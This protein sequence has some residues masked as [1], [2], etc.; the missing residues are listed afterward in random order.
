MASS[1]TPAVLATYVKAGEAKAFTLVLQTLLLRLEG[2]HGSVLELVSQVVAATLGREARVTIAGSV[3]KGTEVGASDLDLLVETPAPVTLAQRRALEVRLQVRPELNAAHVQLKKLAIHVHFGGLDVDIVCTNTV[4]YGVQ[5][6]PDAR[7]ASADAAVKLAARALK[8]WARHA[9]SLGNRKVPGHALESLVLHCRPL[10]R[11]AVIGDS[12][13]QLFVDVLQRIA[14]AGGEL[15]AA[16]RLDAA[17]RASLRHR[18]LATLHVFAVSRVLLPGGSFRTAAEVYAWLS[19]VPGVRPPCDTPAGAVP[20]WLLQSPS[21]QR[22]TDMHFEH[23]EADT[24]AALEDTGLSEE[25]AKTHH[26]LLLMLSSPLGAFTTAAAPKSQSRKGSDVVTEMEALA[27]HAARGSAV[28]RRM[29]LAREL[30]MEAEAAMRDT[31]SNMARAVE[32]FSA[33]LRASV[34][35]GDPF[36]G[37]VFGGLAAYAACADAVLASCHSDEDALLLRAWALHRDGRWTDA[38][39]VHTAVIEQREPDDAYGA[40]YQRYN[41]RGNQGRWREALVDVERCAELCPEEP[42]FHYWIAVTRRNL[43]GPSNRSDGEIC[44]A[45]RRFL[46]LAS[47]EGRKVAPALYDMA[48]LDLMSAV[49]G[50]DR[51]ALLVR[52]RENVRKA[53]DAEALQL[54]VFPPVDCDAK[55][56]V[57]ELICVLEQPTVAKAVAALRQGPAAASPEQLRKEGNAAFASRKFSEA[58]GAYSQALQMSPGSAELLANRAAARTALRFFTAAAEDAAAAAAARPGWSKPHYRAAQAHLGRKDGAAALVAAQRASE[59]LPADESVTRVLSEAKQLAILQSTAAPLPDVRRRPQVW[60]RVAFKENAHIVSPSGGAAFAC[61]ADALHELLR[62]GAAGG[63]TLILLPGVHVEAALFITEP[64]QLLGWADPSGGADVSELRLLAD[65]HTQRFILL[66]AVG[67]KDIVPDINDEGTVCPVISGGEV[68]LEWLRLVQPVGLPHGGHC[69]YCTGGASLRVIGCSAF[70]PDAPCFCTNGAGSRLSLSGVTV[71]RSSAAVVVQGGE[72]QAEGCTFT[73]CAR[74]AVEA[75]EGGEAVLRGCSFNKCS[76]QAALIYQSGKRL[77]LHS[78]TVKQCGGF[79][80]S[81]VHLNEGI[82]LL[83]DCIIEDNDADAVMVEGNGMRHELQEPVALLD[84]CRLERN[85][86]GLCI[87]YGS[88]VVS[89]CTF[90]ANASFGCTVHGVPPNKLV[91]LRGNTFAKN[92]PRCSPTDLTVMGQ[93]LFE[94][95]VRLDADNVLSAPPMVM[96]DAEVANI[97]EITRQKLRQLGQVTSPDLRAVAGNM[98]SRAGWMMPREQ[99]VQNHMQA[100]QALQ[101]STHHTGYVDC[102]GEAGKPLSLAAPPAL[103]SLQPV[104]V[105]ELQPGHTHRGC[106]LRGRL[107]VPPLALRGLVTLLED[108]AGGVVK[109]VVYNLLPPGG[110][111]SAAQRER[112]AARVLP[113]HARLAVLEPLFI[114]LDG[115]YGV[116]VD[117]PRELAM[118]AP[119]GR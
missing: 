23:F 119:A 47:P 82:S 91:A 87:F 3:A 103:A 8:V 9:G 37:W 58:E 70:T 77:E 11:A 29:L 2:Q 110:D 104:A 97:Q 5:P 62:E 34:A 79:R 93:R 74:P 116:R 114:L 92:G 18:A 73:G 85:H 43:L 44:A 41:L 30:W 28:A 21:E 51:T 19:G 108:D 113:K 68:T 22:A 72:L 35:D 64:V 17:T 90:T 1:T 78:C 81:A 36:S 75:R 4:E 61:I 25:D 13:L 48:Q 94:L 52:L 27:M 115:T 33:A 88:A 46:A 20:C 67:P 105:A 38:E 102:F 6:P 111:L 117:D 24:L 96:S 86:S 12:S 15:Q 16:T 80:K 106:V 10:L 40:L 66:T 32:Y 112:T 54:P 84:N 39:A 56:H 83:R 89:R 49:E 57:L 109:L 101:R 45:Y 42:M 50:A 76:S 7:F 71:K 99:A 14:G 100:L 63:L 118:S 65:E 95:C 98:P 59:L 26:A 60:E 53:Q 69:A 31:P 107:I 55:K